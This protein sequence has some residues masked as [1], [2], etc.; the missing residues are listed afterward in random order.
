MKPGVRT[1]AFGLV[2]LFGLMAVGALLPRSAEASGPRITAE[3]ALSTTELETMTQFLPQGIRAG[4]CLAAHAWEYGFS[5]SYPQGYE[6]ITGYRY[7]SWH[8]RYITKPGVLLQRKYFA[9]IQQYLLEF[10]NQNRSVLE[11]KRLKKR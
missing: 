3:F 5:R 7:E 10:L 9:D 1:K 11:A 6:S 2:V 8:Y 4:R